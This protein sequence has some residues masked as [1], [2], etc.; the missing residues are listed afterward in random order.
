M[1]SN[2]LKNEIGRLRVEEHV[3]VQEL[4]QKYNI[5]VG[6]ISRWTKLYMENGPVSNIRASIDQ[7]DKEIERLKKEND[8]LKRDLEKAKIIANTYRDVLM[9]FRP[10]TLPGPQ[11]D[12][13]DNLLGE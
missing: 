8:K 4:S 13:S 7:K 1:Y 10:D 6:T 12:A 5:S 9:M 2:D 3:T 11:L